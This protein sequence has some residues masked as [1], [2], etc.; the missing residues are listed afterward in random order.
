MFP[1]KSGSPSFSLNVAINDSSVV[2][3][4]QELYTMWF[5]T[6]SIVACVFVET[7]NTLLVA[8]ALP[9]S[10]ILSLSSVIYILMFSIFLYASLGS[11]SGNIL[12][13]NSSL[14]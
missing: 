6:K 8:I 4:S 14:K 9:C 7:L 3:G 5:L 11:S 12:L 1:P 2:F 10:T 13:I